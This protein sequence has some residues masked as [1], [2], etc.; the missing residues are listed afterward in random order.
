MSEPTPGAAGQP[1]CP[2][3]PGTVSY[4]R[5]QR[6][7]RPTCP[8][9]QVPAPVGV[10][11][12]DCAREAERA[13]RQSRNAV[14]VRRG[15]P[16][17]VLTYGIIAANV[18][19]YL[20]GYATGSTAWLVH[21]GFRPVLADEAYRWVTSAFVHDGPLHLAINMYVLYQ[22]GAQLEGLIGRWRF[23]VVYGVSLLAGSLAIDMLAPQVSLHVGASGA[24]MGLIAAWAVLLKRAK[25]QWRSQAAFIGIWIAVG[26][27][28]PGVSWE[29]HLGGAIGGAA[30]MAVLL[31]TRSV[32]T[33]R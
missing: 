17:P 22:F 15:R 16:T 7:E 25:L 32:R 6:C 12:V 8:Q 27:L 31:A 9:C 23:G 19:F 3:H 33:R 5:C 13:A 24:I 4:V 21:Y 29:G 30:A 10:L 20:Y 18:L 28:V 26:F 1:V 11:C 14:G 2:R